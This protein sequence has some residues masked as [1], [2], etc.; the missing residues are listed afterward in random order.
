MPHTV[1]A[2]STVPIAPAPVTGHWPIPLQETL[3]G[4]S[5]SVSVGSLGSGA[6]NVLSEPSEHLW[7]VWGS[8][9]NRILALLLSFLGFS[10]ALGHGVPF[11]DG[12]KHLPVDG[13]S[14]TSCNFRVLEGEDE[15]TSF[16]STIL[17][18]LAVHKELYVFIQLFNFSIFSILLWA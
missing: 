3:K 4:R 1:W 6:Y 10:F 8:I 2:R 17:C 18:G 15:C 13:C 14:A 12:I 9:L 11:F 7:L 5:G 16:N